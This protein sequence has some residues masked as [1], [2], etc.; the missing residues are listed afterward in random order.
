MPGAKLMLPEP[1]ANLTAAQWVEMGI[2]QAEFSERWRIRLERDVRAPDIGAL[3]PDF[4]LKILSSAG[5][6]TEEKFRLS[7]ARGQPV[8]LIFGSYT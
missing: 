6:E 3:A 2:T 5:E 7:S 1:M 8:G 4:D